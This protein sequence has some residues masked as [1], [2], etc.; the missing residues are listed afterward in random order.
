M[1]LGAIMPCFRFEN[2]DAD[3][4]ILAK[5]LKHLF[6]L[7]EKTKHIP[8]KAPGRKCQF[9]E[10]TREL[11]KKKF[12][13]AQW[14]V[15]NEKYGSTKLVIDFFARHLGTKQPHEL[16][17]N[18]N[19]GVPL[20]AMAEFYLK[21]GF[22]PRAEG[23]HDK[24]WEQASEDPDV[25]LDLKD[26]PDPNV[27]R[28]HFGYPEMG[29][30]RAREL[31]DQLAQ[32]R[33]DAGLEQESSSSKPKVE[34]SAPPEPGDI[35]MHRMNISGRSVYELAVVD[36]VVSLRGRRGLERLAFN[37]RNSD[38]EKDLLVPASQIVRI[39]D[40]MVEAQI[41]REREILMMEM[42]AGPAPAVQKAKVKL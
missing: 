21:H 2:R 34:N 19:E 24:G 14:H 33:H 16:D 35:V 28:F 18:L 13:L 27:Y 22:F 32:A 10:K 12:T 9:D 11:A 26:L 20:R 7:M 40:I 1:L 36:E 38:N 41:L 39:P 23:D 25:N 17:P 4:P 3:L 42:V 37:L 15:Y 30:K 31:A 6:L 29:K 8:S 5:E